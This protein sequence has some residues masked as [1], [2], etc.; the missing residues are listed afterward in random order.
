MVLGTAMGNACIFL[1]IDPSIHHRSCEQYYHYNND[2]G[3]LCWCVY[4]VQ[5]V[6]PHVPSRCGY[7][8]LSYRNFCCALRLFEFLPF[9]SM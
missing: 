7:I 8:L 9:F 5:F 3:I 1:Q 4:L 6:L 2:D